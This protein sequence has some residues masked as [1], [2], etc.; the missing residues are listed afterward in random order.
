MIDNEHDDQILTESRLKCDRQKPCQNCK[1]RDLQVQ[2]TYAS[3][4]SAK[5]GTMPPLASNQGDV[6]ERIQ[7][8]E[9]LISSLV[10]APAGSPVNGGSQAAQGS[11]VV[12][13]TTNGYPSIESALQPTTPYGAIV[14]TTEGHHFIGETHWE[15]V[16][17][18]VWLRAL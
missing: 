4:G 16:L 14:P 15:A 17:R 3:D 9:A 6:S 8:L 7:K 2:C 10:R 12:N 11:L 1:A 5:A 18:D 13:E